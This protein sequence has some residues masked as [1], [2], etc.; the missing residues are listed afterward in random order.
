MRD[1]WMAT[2]GEGIGNPARGLGGEGE[3]DWRCG[4]RNVRKKKRGYAYY[5]SFWSYL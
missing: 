2:R 1:G 3:L 4:W 5:C